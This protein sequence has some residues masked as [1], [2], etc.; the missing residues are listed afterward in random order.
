[1][2]IE[3]NVHVMAFLASGYTNNDSAFERATK[4][5]ASDIAVVIGG[6]IPQQD[7]GYL[8]QLNQGVFDQARPFPRPMTRYLPWSKLE[9]C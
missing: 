8:L 3:E 2:A 7:Y 1:M 5:G 9:Q 4:A 6:V